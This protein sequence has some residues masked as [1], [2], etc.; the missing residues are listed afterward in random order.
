MFLCETL[1]VPRLDRVTK[2]TVWKHIKNHYHRCC[3]RHRRIHHYSHRHSQ[4][5]RRRH[6][7]HHRCHHRRRS[8]RHHRHHHRHR[9]RRRRRRHRHHRHRITINSLESS[10]FHLMQYYNDTNTALQKL[11]SK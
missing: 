1:L 4:H 5:H 3:R 6:R 11:W 8:R 2:Y 9:H 7:C 10:I